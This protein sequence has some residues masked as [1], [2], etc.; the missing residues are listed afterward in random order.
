VTDM[1]NSSGDLVDIYP[2]PACK[3]FN[4]RLNPIAS[5][6]I[7]IRLFDSGGRIVGNY[8]L[9]S[10]VGLN[11]YVFDVN[12]FSAGLYYVEFITGN[13]KYFGKVMINK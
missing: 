9:N 5:K 3:I 7:F 8:N 11:Q 2:N 13:Q 6:I 10:F 4:I 1:V 12:D